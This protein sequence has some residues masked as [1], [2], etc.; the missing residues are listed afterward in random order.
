MVLR[1]RVFKGRSHSTMDMKRH[2][3]I[4]LIVV[5]QANVIETY[6][7]RY[8]S[9][10]AVPHDDINEL[11]TSINLESNKI[12]SLIDLEFSRYT[13]L[14]VLLLNRNDISVVSATAFE[15]TQIVKLDLNYNKLTQI[16]DLNVINATLERLFLYQNMIS[17]ITNLDNL[18]NLRELNLGNNLYEFIPDWEWNHG[19]NILTLSGMPNIASNIIN[20]RHYDTLEKLFLSMCDLTEF[21]LFEGLNDT[22]KRL[23]LSEN[24][25]THVHADRLNMLTSLEYLRLDRNLLSSLPPMHGIAHSLQYLYLYDNQF[26]GYNLS[27]LSH[28]HD[29]RLLD[30]SNNP[31][32]VWPDF[33]EV[34]VHGYS[35][36]ILNYID[37]LPPLMNCTFCQFYNVYM[38]HSGLRQYPSFSTC[39][40]N[41]NQIQGKQLSNIHLQYNELGGDI[42]TELFVN[43]DNLNLANNKISHINALDMSKSYCKNYGFESLSLKNNEF[44]SLYDFPNLQESLCHESGVSDR[45]ERLQKSARDTAEFSIETVMLYHITYMIQLNTKYLTSNLIM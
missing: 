24:R 26:T 28:L 41:K 9:L 11:E 33:S 22:I 25:I 4:L 14:E 38:K 40:S 35:S 3:M 5:L 12:D 29:I 34:G 43:A 42:P 36:L 18:R 13:Q 39:F 20:F 37:T 10:T 31:M 1:L 19:L 27:Q 2:V 45:I 44:E 7:K 32:Q 8:S 6:T 17:N 21:P 15:Q 23:Y 30:L 16:P